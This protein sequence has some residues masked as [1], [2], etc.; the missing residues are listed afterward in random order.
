MVQITSRNNRSYITLRNEYGDV[1][2]FQILFVATSGHGKG[3][4]IEHFI[5]KWRE[6]TRGIVLII[7]DPKD[8]AEGS[9]VMYKPEKKYHT[10]RLKLDGGLATSYPCKLYHPFTFNIPKGYLPDINFF[11]LPLKSMTREDW[12]I[13]TESP[14]D[15]ESIK[16]MMRVSHNIG[17][18]DGLFRFLHDIERIVRGNKDKR[19]SIPDPKNFYLSVGGGTSKSITEI[20]NLLNPFKVNY[21]LRKDT[22]P[23]KLNWLDILTDN[24]NYHVFLSMWLKDDKLKDFMVLNLLQQIISNRNYL[25]KPL[26]IVIPE[27]LKQCPRNAMGYKFFLSNAIADALVTVRS[28]GRGISIIGDTQNWYET[29]DKLKGS[30]KQTM[31]G[32]LNTKDQE[33]VCK[34][35]NYKR[36]VREKLQNMNNNSYF[37]AGFEDDDPFRLFFPR[38]MHKEPE[39]NWI[40]MYNK[41]FRGKTK[42]YDDL[43]KYMRNEFVSEEREIRDI[44]QKRLKEEKKEEEAKA[45][46]KESKLKKTDKDNK[47]IDREDKNK[48][49]IMKQ[50]YN[51]RNNQSIIQSDRSWRRIG[52]QLGI[53]HNTAK[54]Y[55]YAY[56][57][58]LDDCDDQESIDGMIGE[59]VTPEEIDHNFIVKADN[60]MS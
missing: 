20:A 8:E 24:Q 44:I 48:R 7:S 3:L 57:K 9:F 42:K 4:A 30:F 36:D 47:K 52:D 22:C 37:L 27:L 10:Y 23:Y 51:I 34:A 25:K 28:M 56:K 6:S 16:L 43:V 2:P 49:I 18:S 12:S 46:E 14:F 21:F 59:G 39:Y 50:I 1:I 40:E 54:K 32:G 38:H 5:E 33:V 35:M 58:L 19:K 41:H 11:T 45:L 26:L 15:S 31:F 29:N 17:R 53:S 55:Y 13:L 60:D